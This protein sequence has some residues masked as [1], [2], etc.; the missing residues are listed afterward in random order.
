MREVR[1]M[2]RRNVALI[3][4]LALSVLISV[5]A[6]IQ[7]ELSRECVRWSTR[8]DMD[9]LGRVYRTKVCAEFRPRQ[10]GEGPP[11]DPGDPKAK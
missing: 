6:L 5:V 11:F 2:T 10:H 8:I 7:W 9:D 1:L 3:I 4:A